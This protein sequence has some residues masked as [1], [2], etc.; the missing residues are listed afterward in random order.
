M[1]TIAR[2]VVSEPVRSASETWITIVDLLT[3]PGAEPAVRE[4][5]LAVTGIASSLIVTEAW[6]DTPVVVHGS[7]PRVRIYCL[8]GDDAIIGEVANESALASNPVTDDWAMSLPSPADDLDWVHNALKAHS[9]HITARDMNE[10]V[11]EE[12]QSAGGQ[13]SATLDVEAFRGL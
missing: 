7:G 8:Y 10:A 11:P 4:E 2:R 13:K 3:A 5:L 1:T 9:K 6:K 12:K